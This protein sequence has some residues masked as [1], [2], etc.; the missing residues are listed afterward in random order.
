MQGDDFMRN[1][2]FQRTTSEAQKKSGLN[3]FLAESYNIEKSEESALTS[4]KGIRD[5]STIED[6][7]N[8]YNT[9]KTAYDDSSR[10]TY[11][12]N[13]N[14]EQTM[15]AENKKSMLNLK[16]QKYDQL[17]QIEDMLYNIDTDWEALEFEEDNA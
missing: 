5:Y 6:F 11:L 15:F 2:N 17:A 8:L 3:Q 12:D 4:G 14:T 13:V 16:K 10:M 7:E 9:R 1:L